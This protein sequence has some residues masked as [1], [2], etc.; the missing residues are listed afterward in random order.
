MPTIRRMRTLAATPE[1]IWAIVADPHHMP[2]WWPRVK[3]VES[4]DEDGF[5]QVLTTNKGESVRADFRVLESAPPTVRRWAQELSG[6]PFER[7]LTLSETEIRLE[8]SGERT[9]VVVS[10]AQRL[11]GLARFGS[12]MVSRASARQLDDALSGLEALVRYVLHRG[13]HGR[14]LASSRSVEGRCTSDVLG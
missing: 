13:R 1:E 11:R 14:Q 9:R 3:R 8:R 5:T 6:T 4:V 2:R 10:R 7:I 12:F